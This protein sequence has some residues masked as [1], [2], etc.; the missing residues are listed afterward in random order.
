MGVHISDYFVQ[1]SLGDDY[2]QGIFSLSIQLEG[3]Q[4][5][6][7]EI[8]VLLKQPGKAGKTILSKSLTLLKDSL[9]IGDSLIGLKYSLERLSE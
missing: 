4:K 2:R 5:K 8:S 7:T 6:E 9:E 3:I 1:A